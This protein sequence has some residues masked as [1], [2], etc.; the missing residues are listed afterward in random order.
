METKW[1]DYLNHSIFEK[2]YS[3]G[4]QKFPIENSQQKS[5]ILNILSRFKDFQK[6]IEIVKISALDEFIGPLGG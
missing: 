1:I 6:P 4:N 5:Q 2:N 3:F